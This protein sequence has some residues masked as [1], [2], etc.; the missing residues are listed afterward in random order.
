M[1]HIAPKDPLHLQVAKDPG[2]IEGCAVV[3]GG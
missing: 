3:T 1:E 2:A